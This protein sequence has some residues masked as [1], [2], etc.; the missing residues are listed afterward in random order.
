MVPSTVNVGFRTKRIKTVTQLPTTPTKRLQ[1]DGSLVEEPLI[2]V[3]FFRYGISKFFIKRYVFGQTLQRDFVTI[4][5]L[6]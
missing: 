1:L 6:A 4:Q 5:S 2:H 3:V